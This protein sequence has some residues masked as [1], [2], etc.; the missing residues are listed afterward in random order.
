MSR[1]I[2][3]PACILNFP[4]LRQVDRYN[5]NNPVYQVQGKFLHDAYQKYINDIRTFLDVSHTQLID[6]RPDYLEL[7]GNRLYRKRP[8]HPK[9]DG[10][11]Y[12]ISAKCK[13]FIPTA[14]GPKMDNKPFI[15][16]KSGE[17]VPEDLELRG[18][19]ACIVSQPTLFKSMGV[20]ANVLKGV[21]I[22]QKESA[23]IS[24]IEKQAGIG[25]ADVVKSSTKELLNDDILDEKIHEGDQAFIEKVDKELSKTESA[26]ATA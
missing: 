7:A 18:L 9:G 13:E 6:E 10:K 24:E 16:Y 4:Y 15:N 14:T 22:L 3:S 11:H 12:L 5:K 8:Q 1:K 25:S 17:P 20:I 26:E 21:I 2:V 23:D 19:V